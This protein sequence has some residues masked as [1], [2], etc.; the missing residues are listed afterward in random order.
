[1]FVCLYICV[2]VC[3]CVCLCV[4]VCVYVCVFMCMCV[5][6]YVCVPGR[7]SACVSVYKLAGLCRHL[8]VCF[9]ACFIN[10]CVFK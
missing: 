5:C 3:V 1:M 9:L 4:Y 7:A 6:E 8:S 2:C 10:A